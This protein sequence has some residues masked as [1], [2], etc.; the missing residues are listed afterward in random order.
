[1]FWKNIFTM[2]LL[3]WSSFFIFTIILVNCCDDP[4]AQRRQCFDRCFRTAFFGCCRAT[5]VIT[6]D[7]GVEKSAVFSSRFETKIRTVFGHVNRT[8]TRARAADMRTKRVKYVV[9]VTT[10]CDD[11]NNN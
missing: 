3:I 11:D 6:S 2:I 4:G 7:R 5:G 10:R 9:V 1:V 8:Q